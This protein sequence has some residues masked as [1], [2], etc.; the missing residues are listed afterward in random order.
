MWRS[1]RTRVETVG[2]PPGRRQRRC[3]RRAAGERCCGRHVRSAAAASASSTDA[4]WTTAAPAGP[5]PAAQP[6]EDSL[7]QPT[8]WDHLDL[9]LSPTLGRGGAVFAVGFG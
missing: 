2:V 1:E 8:R 4:L 6:G 5:T 3:L 9:E 7:T